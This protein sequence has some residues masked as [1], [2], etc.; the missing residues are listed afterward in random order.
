MGYL[1]SFCFSMGGRS[2][3]TNENSNNV[4]TFC[5]Y[6]VKKYDDMKY[7]AIKSLFKKN[8]FLLIQE[9]W[10]SEIE[11]I[12]AFK[13]DFPN[14]EC[15]SANK[16][17][18][19]GIRAGRPYGGVGICY[20]S[21]INCKIENIDTRSKSI[22][23]M[24]ITI[25]NICIM[26]VNVYMPCSDN[27]EALE[28]YANILLE[29]SNICIKNLAQHI[30]LGGDWNADL[31]RN[32]GRTRLLREFIQQERL[33]NPLGIDKA[34]VQYTY[35][36]NRKDGSPTTTSIIDHFLISPNLKSTIDCYEAQTLH[37]NISDH[38]PLILKLNIDVE[39]HKTYEKEF[40]PCVAWHKCNQ[41]NINHY[42]E[43]LDQSLLQFNPLHEALR[44]R[45]YKCTQ[46]IKYIH[47]LHNN[48]INSCCHASK[49]CL[50]HTTQKNCKKVIPGWKEYVKEHSDIA[51][52]WHEN[53]VLV[54]RPRNGHIAD[55]RR[56]TRLKY[57]YAIRHVVKENT[58]VHNKLMAEAISENEDR[59]L[60]DEVRKISRIN[61]ELPNAMDGQSSIGE[62][63]DIF[64]NKYE[65]L[66]NSVS[67]N[68]HELHRLSTDINSRIDTGCP[69]SNHKYSHNHSITVPEVKKAI[70][71]LKNGKKEENGLFSNHFING[72]DRLIIT[73]TLLFN[74][75]LI[76]GIAPDELL[77]GTMIPLIKDNRGNKQCSENYRAL[78]IG[79]SLSKILDIVILNQQSDKL[80]TSDLQ[81]GFKE[82]SSTTMCTFMALETIEYYKSKNSN[83]H[84]LL[85]DASKA[86]DRVNYIKLFNKLLD[87]GMCPL[88][89]RLLLN[90]YT[91]QK[92]QVKWNN[93]ISHKFDV[94]NGVRQGGV[95]SPLLFSVYIDELLEKLKRNGIGC[96]LGHHYVGALGYA[97]DIM[98]L[99]PSVSGLKKMI[100]I[101]EEYAEEHCIL[102]N[103][104]KSKYL[105]FGNYKYN[106]TVK[107][108]N[109]VVPRSE[110]APHLGHMLHTDNTTDEL[111]DHAVREFN[112]SYYGFISKFESCN[113]TA[114]NKLF[115]QYC[116]SMYG[117]QLWNMTS[118]KVRMLYTQWRKAHR[119]VLSVPYMTHCDLLPLIADNM[120][121][122]SILDCKY[123]S[124][125][126]SIATSANKIVSYT[127]KS[128][129]F[130]HTS[131]LGKN[132][133]HIM[134]KYELDIDNIVSFS[135][136]KVKEI[137]YNKWVDS[138]NAEYPIYA[139]IIRE[140]IMMK[141]ERYK[142]EFYDNECD[143]IIDFCCLI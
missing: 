108:N 22:C 94:T 83:V 6:N 21:N 10:L 97:D 91:K 88:T 80:K 138:V 64:T 24:K 36:S 47:E 16:M 11:F 29:I 133:T 28:E 90:M 20:H 34:N 143:L 71:K 27:R 115:H 19:G 43:V 114:K 26:L 128:K 117:S 130:D 13:N 142:R 12:R 15:I 69:N 96:F 85:L 33:F 18:Q 134:H 55:M 125:Y 132:M 105:V 45:E 131:T 103:G 53:W 60:W 59:K 109:E 66:Y 41:N 44:C 112:K 4:I 51:K 77:M 73:I 119:Q 54:G 76:H 92:L 61:N 23:A 126:K 5:S 68:N 70:L 87:R 135:K 14:S 58:R 7:D 32:D 46:H 39:Y 62:I 8:T 74:C 9:T 42:K 37:N 113:T 95:L 56:K 136:C 49:T 38:I 141:E 86:F 52:M 63:T 82:K 1:L 84:V 89:V 116:C 127:A 100:K 50:P 57:H 81:F 31:C 93:N 67:F 120:P 40:K 123:I 48:I 102:F 139:K 65:H 30:I 124:F 111:T 106:P 2:N 35:A 121:L 129:L 122:E 25:N 98:L 99:C 3:Q 17:D 118:L 140:M 78:T 101:C 72:T 107:V 137:C 79:T 104:K 110:S 75:M